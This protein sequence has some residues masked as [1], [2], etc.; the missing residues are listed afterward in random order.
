MKRCIIHSILSLLLTSLYAALHA[1]P[2][3]QQ[4]VVAGGGSAMAQTWIFDFTIGEAITATIGNDPLCTQGIQQ[5]L[6]KKDIPPADT[7]L[8]VSIYPNPVKSKLYLR[9]YAEQATVVNVTI[10]AVTGQLISTHVLTLSKGFSD[11]SLPMLNC[12]A[13]MYLL[14]AREPVSGKRIIAKLIKE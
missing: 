7:R 1:Q 6:P 2:S 9:L 11:H 4:A 8:H 3:T 5:P 10:T 13:G 12:R 14:T